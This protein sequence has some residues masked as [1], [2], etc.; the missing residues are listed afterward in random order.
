MTRRLWLGIAL[1]AGVTGLLLAC[2]SDQGE[3][4]VESPPVSRTTFPPSAETPPVPVP[5]SERDAAAPS[6]PVDAPALAQPSPL[7]GHHVPIVLNQYPHDRGA[8]TQGLEWHDGH[9]LESTGIVGESSLRLVDPET[10]DATML[11]PS[12]EELFAEGVTV[13]DGVAVQLTY[14]DRVLLRTPLPDEPGEAPAPTA[15]VDEAYE[16]EGWGLCFDGTHL[17]MS[18][19]SDQLEFRRPDTFAVERTV[20]VTLGDRSIENLNELECVG[21][22]ILANVWQTNSIV[23]V[24]SMSGEV[25]GS[26][27]ASDLVPVE[28]VES[29]SEVLNGIAYNPATDTYWLTGK[30]WPVMYEV[31]FTPADGG[32]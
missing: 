15:R 27:D 7:V 6:F 23:A 19:G 9:L 5:T 12:P 30:R 13:V 21:D 32:A 14:Q 11:L 8:F 18:D 2:S 26:I 24:D 4:R 1:L 3:I 10:G 16:G 29:S 20:E 17:V 25:Q 22:Q 31:R 28:L